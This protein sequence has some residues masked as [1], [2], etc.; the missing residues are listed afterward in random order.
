MP[1]ESAPS[2]GTATI[3]FTDLVGSTAQRAR[4]GEDAAEGLRRA[5]DRMLVDTITAHHGA[6]AKSVGDGIMAT[7]SAAADAVAAAVAIQQAVDRDNRRAAVQLAVR[8]GVSLGDVTREKEDCFGTPVIEAA[9][10][11]GAAEGGQ[12]LVAELVRLTARGRGGHTFKPVGELALKGLPDPVVACAVGWEPLEQPALSLPPRLGTPSP[13]AMVGRSADEEALALAWAKAKQGERQVVL[14]AGE[15]GIGKTRLA[16]EMARTAHADGGAVLFGACDEDVGFPYRPFVEALRHYVTHAPDDVLATHVRTHRGELVR[17]V[18]ELTRRIADVPAPQAAEAETER[19]LLFEAVTGLLATASAERPVVLVLDDLH[20]AGIPDLLLLK[21]IIRASAPMRLLIIGTYRDTDLSRTHPLTSMLA[22]LRREAGVDRRG[23]RGLDDAAVMAL[24]AASAGHDLTDAGVALAH[25][26]H[27]E[28]EGNPFFITEILR[29]LVESHAVF[30]Q[31]D[32][33]T[34]DGDIPGLG[35]P[36][37]VKEVIGRR[38]A[39]LSEATNKVLSL[40]AVI[41]RQFDL[42]LLT[43][44]AD[45][46]EDAVLDALD[47]AA[48]AALIAELPGEPEHWSFSHALIR[49]TLHEE[50]SA[51][52]RARLHRRIGEALE[53]V[54]AVTPGARIDE[55]ARHWLAATQVSDMAKAIRYAREAG[56]R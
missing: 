53:E 36:E 7:F 33:W 26:L 5:H 8:I 42:G 22:D 41:G 29:N 3:L 6:V 12:I 9:R 49:T 31:G 13:L 11:C 20:W 15:P 16:A 19:F 54:T 47:E 32:H 46:S 56:D 43:R 14:V 1:T 39:R 55:L 40:A 18:P 30:R 35:I 48:A 23:L 21:H 38:L 27:R 52:R 24:V 45:L 25:V 17:L 44:V 4:L 50:L 28:T 10:L 37:G 34:Y 51:T 2:T